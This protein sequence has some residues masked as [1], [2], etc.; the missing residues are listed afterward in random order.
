MILRTSAGHDS[1]NA[2][3]FVGHDP[4]ESQIDPGCGDIDGDEFTDELTAH[5]QL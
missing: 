1:E 3:L 4:G 5:S 2:P